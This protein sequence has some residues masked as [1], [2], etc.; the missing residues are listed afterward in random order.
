MKSFYLFLCCLAPIFLNAQDLSFGVRIGLNF[1]KFISPSETDA[2]GADL[3]SFDT[4]TGFLIGATSEYA[5]TDYFGLR[6]E[7][8]YSQKGGKRRYNGP[9]SLVF[10]PGTANAVQAIGDRFASVRVTNS[11]LDLPVM[12]YVRLGKKFRLYGGANIGIL[13]GSLGTGELR[14]NGVSELNSAPIEFTATVDYNYQKDEGFGQIDAS[15]FI[16]PFTVLADGKSVV[17]PKTLSAYYLDFEER[18]ESYYNR[19]E[20]GLTGALAFYLNSALYISFSAN[21][22]L[23]D[24]S[25]DFYDFSYSETDGLTRIKRS[26]KDSQLSLQ[27][28]LGFQ[29]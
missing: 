14:F 9:A 7:L 6:A 28:S 16:D 1:N 2:S 27:G 18:T 12:A 23:T 8:L 24:A 17:V 19:I 22:G 10:N 26:D 13:L 25:N 11:Y 5:L 4:N 3:E 21:Y 20:L 15:S 29:F